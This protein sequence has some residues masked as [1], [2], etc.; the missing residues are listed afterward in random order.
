MM[1]VLFCGACHDLF[2]LRDYYK[3][4]D[5]GR[6]KG[7]YVDTSN[8]VYSG[9]AALPLGIANQDFTSAVARLAKGKASALRC[10]V[11]SP[12]HAPT[13]TKE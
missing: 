10:W 9:N 3:S 7:R 2:G 11:E 4:C 13:W 8:A 1:K 6:T 12:S 5:C